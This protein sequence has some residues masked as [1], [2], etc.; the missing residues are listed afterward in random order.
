MGWLVGEFGG[1]CD[2]GVDDGSPRRTVAELDRGDHNAGCDVHSLDADPRHGGEVRALAAVA[3]LVFASMGWAA[4]PCPPECKPKSPTCEQRIARAKAAGCAMPETVKIVDHEVPVPFPVPGP[5]RI[6]TQKVEVPGPERIIQ[7]TVPAKETG[8][9]LAG[10]G[11][12][13]N[14]EWGVAAVAG[15]QWARGWQLVLGPTWTAHQ[16]Y[17]GTVNTCSGYS[18]HGCE[19]QPIPYHIPEPAHLGGTAL[20][21]YRFK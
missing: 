5:E 17:D 7:V 9:W 21:L 1:S 13:W 10:G 18:F 8:H 6:V 16:G 11:P 14:D 3:A 20:I 19:N 2:R 4:D 12:L 15:Y